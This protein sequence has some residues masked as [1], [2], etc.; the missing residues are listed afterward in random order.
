MQ[1]DSRVV[2]GA[3]FALCAACGCSVH[4][5]PARVTSEYDRVLGRELP[6][7]WHVTPDG[8]RAAQARSAAF[9]RQQEAPHANGR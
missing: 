9:W 1:H 6:T 4:A 5:Q 8:C 7:Y 3:E 2:V